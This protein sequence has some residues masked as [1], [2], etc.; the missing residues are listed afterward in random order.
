MHPVI[1]IFCPFSRTWAFERWLECLE[2]TNH[3]PALTNLVF[4]VDG[5]E[6]FIYNSLKRFNAKHNYRSFHVKMND[7][8]HP[9]E[10][11]LAIRRMR[12]ADLNN[13]AKDMVAECDGDYIIGLED[14]TV[15]D[16]DPDFIFK[17]LECFTQPLV[18]FVEGV[19]VGRWGANI[20][21]AWEADDVFDPKEIKTLLPGPGYQNITGGGFY[22][23]ATRKNLF[24]DC[25]HY[26]SS[27][28]PWGPDVNFGLWLR[29][30]GYKCL[31]NW[32]LIFGHADWNSVR[33]ADDLPPRE[34]LA[35]VIYTKSNV[36]GKWNRTDY[37]QDRY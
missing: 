35:Q 21:G 11:K 37:E 15:F 33:Y 8:W 19:Q 25:A 18:A 12:V 16:R 32:N 36:N 30:R 31:I 17:L 34:Q 28:Q 9:N 7:D 29:Q 26:T 10:V 13:Q 1:T 5:D 6:P 14:D 27:A 22:G 20:I 4:I 24:L 3:D 2:A 23:Y